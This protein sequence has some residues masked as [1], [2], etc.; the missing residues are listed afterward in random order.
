[1]PPKVLKQHP[2]LRF[3]EF[4]FGETHGYISLPRLS[5]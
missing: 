2:E 3:N 5:G 4:G 1:V